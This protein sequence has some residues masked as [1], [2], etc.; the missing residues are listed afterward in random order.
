M[1]KIRH[2]MFETNN[3]YDIK[4]KDMGENVILSIYIDD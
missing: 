2:G 4:T 1:E 3:N